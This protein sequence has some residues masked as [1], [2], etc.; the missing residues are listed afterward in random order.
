MRARHTD[1][2]T[3]TNG[4]IDGWMD[5]WKDR[6]IE[7]WP[8]SGFECEKN[9][10]FKN[11]YIKKIRIC[12]VICLTSPAITWKIILALTHNLSQLINNLKFILFLEIPNTHVVW[13]C[14]RAVP[15]FALHSGRFQVFHSDRTLFRNTMLWIC[16][17]III[18]N[19]N[20]TQS[21]YTTTQM[22]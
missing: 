22:H 19:R 13:R 2:K 11:I 18:I 17:M 8:L 3:R 14:C 6:E 12:S 16:I 20:T 7:Q 10:F 21:I 9:Q 15:L 1:T 4:W 5:G